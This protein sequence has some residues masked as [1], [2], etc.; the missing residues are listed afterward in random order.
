MDGILDSKDL[1]SLYNCLPCSH[2]N[3]FLFNQA[4]AELGKLEV[5]VLFHHETTI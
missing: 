1:Y 4:M 3:A 5:V 2:I